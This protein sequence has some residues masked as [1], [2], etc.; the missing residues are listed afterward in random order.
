MASIEESL[1]REQM[2]RSEQYVEAGSVF[3]AVMGAGTVALTILG[4]AGV[5]PL[6]FAAI[7][8]IA[9]GVGL[10]SEGGAIAARYNDLLWEAKAAHLDNRSLG[11]GMAAES[12]AGVAGIALGILALVGVD[13]MV[14]LPVAAIVFGAAL[15]VGSGMTRDL[16]RYASGPWGGHETHR[17]TRGAVSA[18]SGGQLLVGAGAVTLGVLGVIGLSPL[19]LTLVAL[20]SLGGATLLSGSALGA[21]LRMAH[22]TS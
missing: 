6:Y 4:L 15:L 17:L 20:L 1:T 14:L 5:L 18:A 2:Q 19:L 21:H 10:L 13:P 7:A 9:V 8:V 12:V 3:E 16:N 11:S 22:P